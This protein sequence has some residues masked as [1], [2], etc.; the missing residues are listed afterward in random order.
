MKTAY[1]AKVVYTKE[2]VNVV[3]STEG[4]TQETANFKYRKSW[5]HKKY[6]DKGLELMSL[7]PGYFFHY[8][9]D[10]TAL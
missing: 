3:F 6:V 4:D 2:G 9:W 10:M 7:E 5:S 1:D 8:G